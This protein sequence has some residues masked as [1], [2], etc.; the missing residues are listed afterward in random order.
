VLASAFGPAATPLAPVDGQSALRVAT[1]L[2]LAARIASRCPRARL[3]AELG[4]AGAEELHRLRALCAA[5]GLRLLEL[6]REVAGVAARAGIGLAWLKFAALEASGLEMLGRR[7]A[8]DLDLLVAAQDAPALAAAL[9]ARR[10]TVGRLPAPSHH[11][12]PLAHALLG[13]LEIHTRI[14]GV[15][16]DG[17]RSATWA[18]LAGAG[19]LEPA[20]DARA[21]VPAREVLIAHALV[22]GVAQHA[23]APR[24]YPLW[25]VPADLLDLGAGEAP[26]LD[27]TPVARWVAGELAAADVDALLELVAALASGT[28]LPDPPA[29]RA[30]LWLRHLVA[31]A[32]DADYGRALRARAAL[33]TEPSDLPRPLRAAVA[34]YRTVVLTPAQV[35]AVYGPQRGRGAVMRRQLLR[36]FDLV[37]RSVASLAARRRIDRRRGD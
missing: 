21:T 15:R 3:A 25:R 6:G 4:E 10:F 16:L 22:H 23:R 32:L 35:E 9:L 12:R 31:G 29:G 20:R 27:G 14:P 19:L 34:A 26:A 5:E 30:G 2:D 33:A 28:A 17:R 8:S 37:R 24:G 11:L 1:G 18:D 7:S 36:P 13:A